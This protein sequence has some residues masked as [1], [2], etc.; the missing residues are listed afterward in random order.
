MSSMSPEVPPEL[1]A[2][3]G[4]GGAPGGMAPPGMAPPPGMM[5]QQQAA[6]PEDD[7]ESLDGAG[8]I[9][10]ILEWIRSYIAAENDEQNKLMAEKG[11]TLFQQILAQEEKDTDQLLG[12]RALRRSVT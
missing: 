5:G 3:L 7:Y 1:M 11:S 10:K 8:K 4:G 9:R 2:L 12:N 6:P